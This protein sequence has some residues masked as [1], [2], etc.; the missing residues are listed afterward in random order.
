[1]SAIPQSGLWPAS[2]GV[3]RI[4]TVDEH[5]RNIA[6]HA[7]E[8]NYARNAEHPRGAARTIVFVYIDDILKTAQVADGIKAQSSKRLW[9]KAA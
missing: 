9:S 8:T 1:M 2:G 4:K 7:D 5:L 3:K 6:G